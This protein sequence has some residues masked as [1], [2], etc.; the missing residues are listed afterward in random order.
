ME[1]RNLKV[2]SINAYKKLTKATAVKKN[3]EGV[4][5][6][7]NTDKVEF[8][9]GRYL[10]AAKAN[11]AN[12]TETAASEERLAA[13]AEQYAGDN[14]PVSAEAAAAAILG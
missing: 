11:A 2:N 3:D 5:N 14:C 9:F 13:L 6:A 4:K 8:D 1:I 10:E 12:R 7:V